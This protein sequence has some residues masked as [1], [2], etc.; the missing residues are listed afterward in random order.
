MGLLLNRQTGVLELIELGMIVHQSE[1]FLNGLLSQLAVPAR[2]VHE[3]NEDGVPAHYEGRDSKY[4]QLTHNPF[5]FVVRHLGGPPRLDLGQNRVGVEIYSGQG[6]THYVRV[7]EV[8]GLVVPGGKQRPVGGQEPVLVPVTDDH[9]SRQGQKIRLLTRV[10]PRRRPPFGDLGLVE[11]EGDES[12]IP[13][14]SSLQAIH[15]VLMAVSGKRAPVVP[16]H[17]KCKVRT[18]TRP[19]PEESDRFR[20][21]ARE[22]AEGAWGRCPGSAGPTG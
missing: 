17:S 13:G 8:T 10:L 5:M 9:S 2:P 1:H 6:L 22:V 7:P 12:D 11:E 20:P 18:H 15:D 3:S 21:D 16:G 19:T 14:R 4:L